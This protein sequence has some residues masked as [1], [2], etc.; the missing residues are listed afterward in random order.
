[1]NSCDTLAGQKAIER[2]KNSIDAV[3]FN[4]LL[5]AYQSYAFPPLTTLRSVRANLPKSTSICLY[6]ARYE[7]DQPLSKETVRKHLFEDDKVVDLALPHLRAEF[8]Y[9]RWDDHIMLR[10][11]A[12]HNLPKSVDKI[13]Y[14]D[15]DTVA[16]GPLLPF[17]NHAK[18]E[19]HVLCGTKEWF[20]ELKDDPVFPYLHETDYINSGSLIINVKKWLLKFPNLPSFETAISRLPFCPGAIDQDLLNYFFADS[21]YCFPDDKYMRFCDGYHFASIPKS[22]RAAKPIILHFA[23]THKPWLVAGR[24]RYRR[25]FWKYG[26]CVFPKTLRN[27]YLRK[28]S[29]YIIQYPVRMIRRFLHFVRD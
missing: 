29:I 5:I 16:N 17:Y 21:K 2:S 13:C 27:T 20:P 19:T 14:L 10:L 25:V 23:G 22:Y 1:M 18:T 11:I 3:C 9:G 26:K 15:G 4:L 28:R 24:P 7:N 12:I 8:N 6:L